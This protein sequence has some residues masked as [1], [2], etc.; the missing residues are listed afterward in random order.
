MSDTLVRGGWRE[1]STR[2]W[3]ASAVALGVDY[4]LEAGEGAF[5][6]GTAWSLVWDCPHCERRVRLQIWVTKPVTEWHEESFSSAVTL[7]ID[8]S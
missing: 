3:L 2:R 1:V 4:C 7:H 8:A 5:R 6:R